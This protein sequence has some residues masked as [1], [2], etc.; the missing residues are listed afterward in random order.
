MKIEL[1]K[2]GK[3]VVAAV[4]VIL[5]IALGLYLEFGYS[6][7]FEMGKIPE[8]ERFSTETEH[9]LSYDEKGRLDINMATVD[10]LDSIYGVGKSTAKKIVAY[11]EEH[12]A[13]LSIEE[14]TNVSGIG[15]QT[16]ESMRSS[17]CVR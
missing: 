14:L 12:G 1:T 4:A 6:M 5:A 13:F 8:S 7:K 3:K 17:I 16:V 15:M 2:R 10:E 11:R 9:S